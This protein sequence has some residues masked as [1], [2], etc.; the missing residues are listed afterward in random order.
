MS[1]EVVTVLT[2]KSVETCLGV[3]GTQAWALD[4]AHARRCRYAV[5]CQNTKTDWGDGTAPHGSAFMV[6][7]I[8]DVVPSTE[9]EDRWLITFD[10]YALIDVP[11]VWQG[12]R[13]PVR[14]T[15]LEELGVSLDGVRFEPMPPKPEPLEVA[16]AP[17]ARPATMLTIAE[18]KR[19]LAATFGVGP[20][21][22]EI[23]IRG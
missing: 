10:Q 4:R 12:W 16:E 23:T 5:L 2:A 15:T 1:E 3:G 7:R 13:N 19:A 18:A 20:E 21:A 11:N 14:Y 9:T 6:G 22:I 8:K 17:I